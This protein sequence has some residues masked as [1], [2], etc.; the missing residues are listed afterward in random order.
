MRPFARCGCRFAL[1]KFSIVGIAITLKSG[2]LIV[3]AYAGDWTI[4][5]SASERFTYEDNTD[6]VPDGK[7]PRYGTFTSLN[8]ATSWQGRRWGMQLNSAFNIRKD[9]GPGAVSDGDS[10]FTQS[11]V[12]DVTRL[13]KDTDFGFSS[14]FR[15]QDTTFSELE[16]TG[17]TSQNDNL[18]LTYTASARVDHRINRRTV[19]GFSSSA[20]LVDFTKDSASLTPFV[21]VELLGNLTRN[22]SV[23]TDAVFL[24][25]L[26]Y[27][28]ADDFANRTSYSSRVSGAINT[29]L[30]PRLKLGFKTGVSI[31]NTDE[32]VGF[33]G[34]S[35]STTEVGLIASFNLNYN[36][37]TTQYSLS[38][39]QDFEP[40][41]SGEIEQRTR[42]GMSVSRQVNRHSR[43]GFSVNGVRSSDQSN[44]TISPTYSYILARRW[45]ANLGYIF[46]YQNFE[47]TDAISNTAF[48][49]LTRSLSVL[50]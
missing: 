15:S 47:N 4:D 27:F 14:S 10:V 21:D 40:S 1:V 9:F 25:G 35:S 39:S 26:G 18:R 37:K 43:M 33:S 19:V 45:T 3:P 32:N 36:L 5:A 20:K 41:A 31:I 23:N 44:L 7:E 38:A 11:Q 42:I 6:L 28:N 29:Q 13:G 49:S 22:L 2:A 17:I 30:S 34:N 48:V 12:I 8:T 24:V 16:D 50:P 46:R